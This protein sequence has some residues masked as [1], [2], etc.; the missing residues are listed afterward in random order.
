M[1]LRRSTVI[2]LLLGLLSILTSIS[3]ARESAW[4]GSSQNP[5][6]QTIPFTRTPTRVPNPTTV[7]P[8]LPAPN[9]GQPT[10][11]PTVVQPPTATA[12]SVAPTATSTR[13]SAATAAAIFSPSPTLTA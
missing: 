5:E 7:P 13:A 9:P 10:A 2:L 1:I 6:H 3:S 12:T 8:T 11:T 4:A